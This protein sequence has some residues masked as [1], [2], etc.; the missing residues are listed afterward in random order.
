MAKD[1]QDTLTLHFRLSS[2]YMHERDALFLAGHPLL[3]CRSSIMQVLWVVVL[4]HEVNASFLVGHLCSASVIHVTSVA[5]VVG[6]DSHCPS[7]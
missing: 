5:N 6:D 1:I 3:T 7:N 2:R 4:V